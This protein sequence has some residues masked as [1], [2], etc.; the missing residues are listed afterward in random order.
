MGVDIDHSWELA[1]NPLEHIVT[2]DD[3]RHTRRG[4]VF[5]RTTID[6]GVL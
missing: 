5:L 3:K 4:E 6:E 2:N 1:D